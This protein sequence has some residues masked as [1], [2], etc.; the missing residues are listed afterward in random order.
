MPEGDRQHLDII[1]LLLL[2]HHFCQ[3]ETQMQFAQ[4]ELDLHFPDACHTEEH[5][6]RSNLTRCAGLW[7]ERGGVTVPPDE[8][9]GVQ[10]HFHGVSVQ[11][12]SGNGSSKSSLVQMAPGCN[13]A[14]RGVVAPAMGTIRASGVLPS[15]RMISAEPEHKI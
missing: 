4:L 14:T 2:G 10:Q 12:S 11:N 13:P 8:G 7:R 3:G 5:Q 15:V 1:G 9:M 6:V